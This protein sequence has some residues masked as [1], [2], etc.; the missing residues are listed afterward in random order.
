MNADKIIVIDKG[1]IEA[2]GK[3]GELLE[4]SK[5]YKE[6]W[7]AHIGANIETEAI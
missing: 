2:I 3:H 4:K 6:M 1:N 5:I 7:E